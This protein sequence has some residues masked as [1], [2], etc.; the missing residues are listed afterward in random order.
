MKVVRCGIHGTT[1]QPKLKENPS[2]WFKFTAVMAATAAV[3]ATLLWRRHLLGTSGLGTIA[4]LLALGVAACA[5][6]PR[7]FRGFYRA[8]MTASFHAG[9]VMGRI[10]L[11]IVFLL[12]VTPLGLIL[13][14]T[15]KDLLQLRCDPKAATY[16]CK[17]AAPG[18]LDRQF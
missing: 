11:S 7:W 13:R 15:G 5:L 1:M 4:A 8:G 18:P 16:W 10:L 3:L 6:K 2:E 17:A 14:L 12:V 9:Q